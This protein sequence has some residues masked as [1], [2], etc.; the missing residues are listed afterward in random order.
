V[1]VGRD[2]RRSTGLALRALV[3]EPGGPRP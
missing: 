3:A 1:R 2:A